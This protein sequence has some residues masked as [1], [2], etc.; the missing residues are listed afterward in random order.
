VE[1]SYPNAQN[2]ITT[3][4]LDQSTQQEVKQATD[5][6]GGDDNAGYKMKAH[7]TGIS[8][9]NG[10]AAEISSNRT[11]PPRWTQ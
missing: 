4:S 9:H 8:V 11:G 3:Q 10:T 1:I 2:I 7:M 5:L 6:H